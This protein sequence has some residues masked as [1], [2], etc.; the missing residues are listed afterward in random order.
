M[1]NCTLCRAVLWKKDTW[2][3]VFMTDNNLGDISDYDSF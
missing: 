2:N 3:H 1:V